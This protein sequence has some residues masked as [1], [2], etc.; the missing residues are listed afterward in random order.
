MSATGCKKNL[1][2]QLS[3]PSVERSAQ[4]MDGSRV[5]VAAEIADRIDRAKSRRAGTRKSVPIT[6]DE[7]NP[8][9]GR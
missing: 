5:Q 7:L 8:G 4:M 1:T 9:P 2:Y 6:S 3:H